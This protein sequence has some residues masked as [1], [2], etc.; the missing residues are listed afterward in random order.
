FE[1]KQHWYPVAWARDCVLD[2]PM[3]VT[4]FDED[5]CVVLRGSGRTPIALRDK[6]P[7]RSAAL[8][9]GR[10]TEQ[11]LVQCSYHGWAFD[12]E[13]GECKSIP[14][15]LDPAAA[16]LDPAAAI[17]RL[18]FVPPAKSCAD[19]VAIQV[20]DGMVWMHTQAKTAAEAPF[21]IPRIPEMS[22]PRYK[23]LPAV[24]DFP[25]DHSLLVENI[26]DPDHGLFAH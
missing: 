10:V 23:V 5:Y 14:Q 22:D 2:V 12:G 9:E 18:P 24:R 17:A 4:I 20:V 7:H 1:W 21:P 11:G 15:L 8:S 16:M 25:V 3:K 19:A 26:C 13:D 6:C